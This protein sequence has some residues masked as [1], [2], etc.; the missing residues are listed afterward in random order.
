M[1][2]ALWRGCCLCLWGVSDDPL[3]ILLGPCN[4]NYWSDQGTR[5][6]WPEGAWLQHLHK[7]IPV[8]SS[9]GTTGGFYFSFVQERFLHYPSVTLTLY[10]GSSQLRSHVLRH[11]LSRLFSFLHPIFASAV[12]VPSSSPPAQVATR[13]SGIPCLLN[14]AQYCHQSSFPKQLL[15]YLFAQKPS[16]TPHGSENK[17]HTPS[18]GIVIIY[19]NKL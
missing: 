8:F 3:L 17:A 16:T 10:P 9:R 19:Y 5:G 11:C 1:A 15:W 4:G 7:T 6:P 12:L 18:H 14:P 2:P 13:P